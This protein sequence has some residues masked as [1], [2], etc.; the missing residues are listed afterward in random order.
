MELLELK[1]LGR[2][3]MDDFVVRVV[4]VAS[5]TVVAGVVVCFL[6]EVVSNILPTVDVSVVSVVDGGVVVG[7]VVSVVA[8]GVVI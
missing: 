4:P 6:P 1:V 2:V 3:A 8:P 5:G 7:V